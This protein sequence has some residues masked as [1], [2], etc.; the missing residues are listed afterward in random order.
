MQSVATELPKDPVI[1]RG[2]IVEL[3]DRL[4]ESERRQAEHEQALKEQEQHIQQLLDY[5]TLLKRKRFGPGADRIPAEQLKLFDEAELE[6]LIGELEEAAPPASPPEQR[7]APEKPKERPVRKPL[8]EHLPRV[9]RILDLPESEKQAM[10]ADWTFMPE[11]SSRLLAAR[12]EVGTHPSF[13]AMSTSTQALSI[14][15]SE[16]GA[17]RPRSRKLATA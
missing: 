5:I 16:Y 2:E 13:L 3:Q 11:M 4:A 12:R 17:Q 10:G 8:P 15:T 9:E 14:E 7:P 6:A 1:L